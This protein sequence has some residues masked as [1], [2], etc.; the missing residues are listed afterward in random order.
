MKRGSGN[1]VVIAHSNG[2]AHP[3]LPPVEVRPRVCTPGSR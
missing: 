2:L 3:L 1:T